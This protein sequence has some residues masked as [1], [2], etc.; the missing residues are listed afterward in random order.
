VS[1]GAREDNRG[2]HTDNLAGATPTGLISDPPSPPSIT[3]DSLPA[4]TLP[5][6]PV[7]GQAPNM[8]DCIPSGL[9]Q[10]MLSTFAMNYARLL[11]VHQERL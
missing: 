5:I 10:M 4:A 2:R 11:Q 1:S 7:L 6:Y 3:P 9:V 8:L